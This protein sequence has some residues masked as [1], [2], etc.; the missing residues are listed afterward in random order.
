MMGA[1]A[2]Q[3]FVFTDTGGFDFRAEMIPYALLSVFLF[4]T[5]FYMSFLSYRFG[6]FGLTRLLFSFQ[7]LFM[8]FFGLF[9]LEESATPILYVGIAMILA[10]IVLINS[11]NLTKKEEGVKLSFKWLICVLL[12][13]TANGII[14][15]LTKIQQIRFNNETSNEYMIISL[16]GAALALLFMGLIIDRKKA[17]TVFT[18]GL[19]YGALA[20]ASNGARSL[21]NLFI[22]LWMPLSISSPIKTGVELVITFIVSLLIYK[23]KYSP[24]QLTGV[25]LGAS[26][27]L[28]LTIF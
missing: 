12:N 24:L 6:P 10:S 14:A 3:F 16:G 13:I 21:I 8:V 11:N 4:A 23:E 17:K 2:L 18:K 5:G 19:L 1:Y 25:G 27:V 7:L 15:I 9:Y 22:L 20:G 26:A 28:L